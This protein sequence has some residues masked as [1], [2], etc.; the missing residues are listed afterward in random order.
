MSCRDRLITCG[1]VCAAFCGLVVLVDPARAATPLGYLQT[2]GMRGDAITPL[3]WAMLIISIA[4]IVVVT[5]LLLAGIFRRRE[6]AA[7]STGRSTV[8]RTSGGLAWISIG[9]GISTVVLFAITVWTVVTL[10]AVARPAGP[11][12]AN[13]E[14]TG[15]QWWWEIRYI[16][17]DPSRSFTTANEIHIPVGQQVRVKLRGVDVIHSFWIPALTGK[18]DVIPGQINSTW[19]EASAPGVYR[20]QCT[21]YCGQQHAHMG[22]EVVASSPDDFSMWRSDQL[23][24]APA[25]ASPLMQEALNTFLTRCGICHTVRGT[26]AGGILGPDLSHL[27]SRRTIAAGTLPNTPGALSAWIADPQH[28]KPGSLMPQLNLSGPE[29]SYIRSYLETL[30]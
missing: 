3:L 19:L 29:L 7:E 14:I 27:M 9:V 11:F 30:K 6:L 8:E 12:G 15:H 16:D 2:H 10:A 17:D 18:T 22:L 13:L 24:G 5:I 1:R 21:E 25:P 4:V 20:G 28:I 26:R 23:R